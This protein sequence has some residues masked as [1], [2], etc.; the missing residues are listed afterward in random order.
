MELWYEVDRPDKSYELRLGAVD[1]I[2]AAL[3][4]GE[5]V[6]CVQM[7][8]RSECPDG[9]VYDVKKHCA[10]EDATFFIRFPDGSEIVLY[11]SLMGDE[12]W[13]RVEDN[14][15]G[16]VRLGHA[17]QAA[18]QR[19]LYRARLRAQARAEERQGAH[20]DG[21]WQDAVD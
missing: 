14:A 4:L 6:L 2:E 8:P 19:D 3:E 20:V 15:P 11:D 10:P 12:N 18:V 16:G 13:M 9:Q 7:C 21:A 5:S 17:C 1:G